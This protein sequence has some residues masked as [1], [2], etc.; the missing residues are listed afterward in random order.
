MEREGEK[1]PD[2][3]K[4]KS[5]EETPYVMQCWKQC[6]NSLIKGLKWVKLTYVTEYN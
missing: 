6:A 1:L 2:S 5:V 3:A 4:V